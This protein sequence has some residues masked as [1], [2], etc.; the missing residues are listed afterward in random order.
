MR[1]GPVQRVHDAVEVILRVGLL[2][3]VPDRHLAKYALAVDQR[4]HFAIAAAE[5]EPD[6]TP[7]PLT[8][9][10]RAVA[11]GGREF[12]RGND[13]NR[14]GVMALADDVRTELAGG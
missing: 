4:R 3:R 9:H 14:A 1:G 2:H 12:G 5:V 11:A 13:F 10:R 7:V 6:A 8:A